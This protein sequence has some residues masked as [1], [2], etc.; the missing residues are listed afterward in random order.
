MDGAGLSWDYLQKASDMIYANMV[1]L[2]GLVEADADKVAAN[3]LSVLAKA[4]T[5]IQEMLRKAAA[6][7]LG[8]IGH[9][10]VVR[11]LDQ[12]LDDEEA[13]GVK[14]AMLAALTTI[15]IAPRPDHS[16]SESH[17]IIEDVYH[18]HQLPI[19]S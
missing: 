6:Y 2:G 11:A 19:R 5:H 9:H 1:N 4:R 16:E 10:K 15:N 13:A 8:Q 7:G 18:S 14:D 17:Q 12:F 3:L